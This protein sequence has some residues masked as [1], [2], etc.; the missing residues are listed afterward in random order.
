[1]NKI[2][3]QI[4]QHDGGWAYTVDGVFSE[5]F[6]SHAAALSAGTLTP[7][8]YVVVSS[9]LPSDEAESR[10]QKPV[11]LASELGEGLWQAF[12]PFA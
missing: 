10:I 8:L 12:P 1:M 4:V 9:T 11:E 6:A 3:Y 5:P 7:V 2:V